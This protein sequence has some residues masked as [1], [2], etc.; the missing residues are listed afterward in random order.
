MSFPTIKL[1]IIISSVIITGVIYMMFIS[2]EWNAVESLRESH[3][4]RLQ[5]LEKTETLSKKFQELRTAYISM[6][7]EGLADDINSVI[8]RKEEIPEVL[9]QLEAIAAKTG[10]GGVVMRSINFNVKPAGAR[11]QVDTLEFD[12]QLRASYEAFKEY[13]DRIAGNMR[14]F[15]V[16]SFSFAS[17][18]TGEGTEGEEVIIY[19]FTVKARAYFQQ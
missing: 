17:T 12:I 3:A 8:P 7:E 2:P 15:D 18:T 19:D 16:S 9:V 14:V 6:V 11:G 5:E 13:L 4:V 10:N 1:V